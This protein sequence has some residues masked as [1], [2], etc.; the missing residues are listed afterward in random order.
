MDLIVLEPQVICQF[1]L[2][3]KHWVKTEF[4]SDPVPFPQKV[5]GPASPDR[6]E[7]VRA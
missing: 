2:M 7:S 5:S 1:T 6:V 4:R 3:A